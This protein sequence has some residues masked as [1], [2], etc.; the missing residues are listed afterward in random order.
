M[1][2]GALIIGLI[3]STV[4]HLWLLRAD[5]SKGHTDEP[6]AKATEP[7]QIVPVVELPEPE[8][9]PQPER[10]EPVMEARPQ[11]PP[12]P[13]PPPVRHQP[14]PP[15]PLVPAPVN[16]NSVT[17]RSSVTE[18]G[19]FAGAPEGRQSPVLRINWGSPS[20][21]LAVLQAGRMKLVLLEGGSIRHQVDR[22][23]H[24][25]K[26]APY[27]PEAQTTYSNHLRIVDEVP[28]FADV[29]SNIVLAPR[30]RLAVLLPVSTEQHLQSAQMRAA[31]E[32]GLTMN[33]VRNFAGHFVL[34]GKELAFDVTH[35]Q[36]RRSMP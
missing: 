26:I 7:V 6:L 20:E 24:A 8:P 14:M 32:R 33:E 29:V 2:R 25:W 35:V 4:L 12:V 5:P 15:A 13:E 23:D 11:S 34:K 9:A 27:R 19:D 28:A 10:A 16:K 30:Q 31:F 1:S 3:V 18:Q 17:Q 36:E 22:R 21:A